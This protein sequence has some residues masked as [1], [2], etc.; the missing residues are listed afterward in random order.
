MERHIQWKQFLLYFLAILGLGSLSAISVEWLSGLSVAQIYQ[1]LTLPPL[2]PAGSVFG[3][4]WGVLYIL[5]ALYAS[6]L[7]QQPVLK[8][9]NGLQLVLNIVWTPIFFGLGNVWL[10]LFV[11]LVMDGLTLVLI[12]KDDAKIHYV[13]YPYLA[14][15]IFATYLTVGVLV[16]N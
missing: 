4:A 16:L 10:A 2:S 3:P 15:L 11:I 8:W 13:L 9:L 1:Q 6:T 5:L 14:W 7:W 12:L